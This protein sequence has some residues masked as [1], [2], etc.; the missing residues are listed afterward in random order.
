[1]KVRVEIRRKGGVF[2][3]RYGMQKAIVGD[4]YLRREELGGRHLYVLCLF[5]D[6]KNFPHQSEKAR[7]NLFEPHLTYMEET[8]TRYIGY[9]V[10]D[11]AWVMQEW[12]CTVCN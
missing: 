11:R 6:L 2:I 10:I 4:L 7:L 9:E 5:P 3:H 12:E 8:E 1:M